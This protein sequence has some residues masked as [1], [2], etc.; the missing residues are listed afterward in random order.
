MKFE[1]K[2]RGTTQPQGKPKVYVTGH[3][4]DC[5]QFLQEIEDEILELE[6]CAVYHDGDPLAEYD[7]EELTAGL[8]QMRLFVIPVTKRFLCE[9][10]RAFDVE[11]PFVM[12]RHIPVLPLA[13]E[14][15]MEQL[16]QIKSFKKMAEEATRAQVRNLL[17]YGQLGDISMAQG[18]WEEAKE[19]YLRLLKGGKKLKRNAPR[20]EITQ[21]VMTIGYHNMGNFCLETGRPSEA[22]EYYEKMM[23]QD[24]EFQDRFPELSDTAALAWSSLGDVAM[25]QGQMLKAEWYYLKGLTESRKDWENPWGLSLSLDRM[26]DLRKAQGKWDEAIEYY[27]EAVKIDQD[28]CEK[29]K[30]REGGAV[31]ERRN[32]ALGR[33]KLGDSYLD[34]G[35]EKDANQCFWEASRICRQ[36]SQE[37]GVLIDW[38]ESPR[39]QGVTQE[40]IREHLKN[41]DMSFFTFRETLEEIKRIYRTEMEKQ[42]SQDE[43]NPV[44]PEDV[45]KDL[46]AMSVALGK[47]YEKE[48]QLDKARGFFQRAQSVGAKLC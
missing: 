13:R 32:L 23:G 44:P 37:T 12:E 26:G 2:T 29:A 1:Y 7:R 33:G 25:A 11:F 42:D 18:N 21:L 40:K 20:Q 38:R 3:P 34:M 39:K 14:T 36:L 8:A 19:H 43:K 5:R 28:L 10:N 46:M 47:E 31:G 9:K 4:E 48:K 41:M 24:R 22:E 27:Q 30:A 35:K 16:A 15:G 45:E 6:N 17:T